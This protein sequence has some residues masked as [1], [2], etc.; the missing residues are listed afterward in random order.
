MV[1]RKELGTR[2]K[3]HAA[4]FGEKK[5]DTYVE[6]MVELLSSP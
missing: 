3:K 1:P 6:I 4:T 2:S 5:S